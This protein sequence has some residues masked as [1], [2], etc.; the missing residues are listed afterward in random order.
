MIERRHRHAR[1]RHPGLDGADR[2]AER[3]LHSGR[4]HADQ[5]GRC[6]RS[7]SWASRVT[8]SIEQFCLEHP[9]TCLVDGAK[10]ARGPAAHRGRPQ[11]YVQWVASP[12]GL[13]AP[14]NRASSQGIWAAAPYLHNGSVPTLAQLLTPAAQRVQTFAV[15]PELRPGQHRPRRHPDPVRLHLPGHRLRRPGLGQQQ[16]RPRI[17]HDAVGVGQDGAAGVSE[18]AVRSGRRGAAL[19]A[20]FTCAGVSVAGIGRPQCLG[21][22]ALS[23]Q[24]DERRR[25]HDAPGVVFGQLPDAHPGEVAPTEAPVAARSSR[26]RMILAATAA[27]TRPT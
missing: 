6:C 8:G 12:A 9:I 27:L 20:S 16:L 2:R 25:T 13:A 11:G 21:A 19:H 3:R 1:V 22:G 7:T 23:A 24:M 15:G 18:D 26:A 17:R 10:R 5:A 14:T 4:S